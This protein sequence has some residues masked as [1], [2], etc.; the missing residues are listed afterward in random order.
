MKTQKIKGMKRNKIILIIG[1]AILVLYGSILVSCNNDDDLTESIINTD[2]AAETELEAWIDSSFREPYNIYVEYKWNSADVDQSKDVVP[3]KEN[4]VKPFLKTV[5]KVWLDAY[6]TVAETGDEFMKNY[7][8][9][10][11][12]LIGS[13]SYNSGSV[14]LGLATNGYKITLYT[15]NSFRLDEGGSNQALKEDLRE[16]FRVMHHEFQH[17]LNQ[18]KPYD[19]GFQNISGGYT[20]D[21]TS[22]SDREAREMG[23]ISAYARAADKEDFAET[24]SYYICY[25]DS[26]WDELMNDISNEEGRNYIEQKVASISSYMNES[27]GVDIDALRDEIMKA[28]NEVLEGDLD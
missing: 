2:G 3:P 27:Y 24:I 25:S 10:K 16:F 7:S 21:W 8:C 17:I 15:V 11:L 20:S 18:R 6:N 12:K 9:R 13:G 14:T 4:L 26:E 1:I 22:I 23:Y 5:L 19:V 28:F